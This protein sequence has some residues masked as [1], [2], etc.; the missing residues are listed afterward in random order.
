ML[1]RNRPLAI[2]VILAVLAAIA[3]FFFFQRN[4]EAAYGPAIA[5]CPGPDQYGYLCGAG[6]GFSYIDATNDTF[7]YEDD[8]TVSLALPFPFTFY[9]TT[10]EE[11][12]AGSNGTLQFDADFSP[13]WNQCLADGVVPE[14]GDLIAPYWDDLDL[15]LFGYLETETVGEAPNRIF[16]IEWD[17]VPR[18]G[19]GDSDRVTFEVQLFEGSHD[20][21]ILY[22]DVTT[23]EGSNGREATIG[24][25]SAAQ[26]RALQYSC[27]QA[28]VADAS[29]IMFDHP[30]RPN[31]ERPE[32]RE[33]A[34]AFADGATAKG[35]LALLM[36]HL[37]LN[38]RAAVPGL[39]SYWLGQS[40]PRHTEAHWRDLTGDGRDDLFILW[41]G[42]AQYPQL[43]R[44]AILAMAEPGDSQPVV[45]FDQLLSQRDEPV[46]RPE[47]LATADLTGS[48][49]NDIVIRDD[50]NGL[51][52]IISAVLDDQWQLYPVPDGCSGSVVIRDGNGDGRLD[53]I[54]SDC[55]QRGRAVI[56]WDG[57]QFVL[58]QP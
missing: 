58:Q 41:R 11:V 51:L 14:M 26:G 6:T 21:V 52:M 55:Q 34:A 29:A 15:R 54:R 31:D 20:I 3:T 33:T 4:L 2:A 30:D 1:T 7:L 28:T 43:S 17:D 35:D 57:S 32:A 53:I 23:A 45:H 5:L 27:N 10:Y 50:A 24:L 37:A 42:P 48:G 47:V 49:R 18:Y 12:T 46:V 22:Q 44:L 25:Q 9:G 38:G 19:G 40:P 16:V 39:K 13:W 56:A 8:G 36:D